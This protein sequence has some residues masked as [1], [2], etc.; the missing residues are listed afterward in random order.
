MKMKAII[1]STVSLAIVLTLATSSAFGDSLPNLHLESVQIVDGNANPITPVAGENFYVRAVYTYDNPVCTDYTIRFTV[2]GQPLQAVLNWGCGYSGE[3][4]WWIYWGCWAMD[5]G[6]TYS[7]TVTL[8]ADNVIAESDENDNTLT[9]NFSVFNYSG[10]NFVNFLDYSIF[11]EDYGKTISGLASDLDGD[12]DCDLKDLSYLLH[13][14]LHEPC[15][16]CK[17]YFYPRTDQRTNNTIEA[18]ATRNGN[19]RPDF[20]LK[21][22]WQEPVPWKYSLYTPEASDWYTPAYDDINWPQ[23][24]PLFGAWYPELDYLINTQWT[25]DIWLR[26]TFNLDSD[27][28]QDLLLYAK[29]D[30]DIKVYINGVLAFEHNGWTAGYDYYEISPAAAQTIRQGENLIAVYCHNGGGQGFVDVGISK[31]IFN[32]IPSTGYELHPAL[33]Q[34]SS[35]VQQYMSENQIP[36]GTLSVS[37]GEKIVLSRRFGWADNQRIN[38]NTGKD[39]LR[40]ASNDKLLTKAAIVHLMDQLPNLPD[41]NTLSRDTLI[42][43]I[44]QLYGIEDRPDGIIDV[45]IKKVTVGHL[46]DHRS[47]IYELPWVTQIYSNLGITSGFITKS[48]N[49]RWILRQTTHFEPGTQDQ[50]CSSGYFL[51]RYIVELVSGTDLVSYLKEHI[52]VAPLDSNEVAIAYE[53]LAGYNPDDLWY[54]DIDAPYDRYVNLEEFLA[55]N[56]SSDAMVKFLRRYH[57]GTG[58]SMYKNGVWDL[59]GTGHDN[60]C[61]IFYGGMAGTFSYTLQRRWDEINIC[62]IFNKSGNFNG[63]C[64][65]LYNITDS[66]NPS[67]WEYL[68]TITNADINGD[69]AI[70]EFDLF[71]LFENWLSTGCNLGEHCNGADIDRDNDVDFS[72]FSRLAAYWHVN[73]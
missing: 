17:Y 10:D 67:I 49:A 68:V 52:F 32:N 44:F 30:D 61:G 37:K 65:E 73:Y 35:A 15:S 7:A 28:D 9:I 36:A 55:L 27:V 24:Q 60:G 71:I 42:Y 1:T 12:G 29:W 33:E 11:A 26:K 13:Y 34:Y 21:T 20:I 23:G 53:E 6:G 51:L 31:N 47:G 25:Y 57:L 39:V 14:W 48:D 16:S 58:R 70:N 72:D 54:A 43:K 45:N 2:N 50:Y 40:L 64:D 66:I 46:I 3:T 38:E 22:D 19:L 62:L 8:D 56:A 69:R 18:R 63:L 4:Y 41:G 59:A 5:H